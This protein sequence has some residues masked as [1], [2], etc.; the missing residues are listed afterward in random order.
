M[1]AIVREL[2]HRI[3]GHDLLVPVRH[4]LLAT[5]KSNPRRPCLPQINEKIANTALELFRDEPRR[6][7][8]AHHPRRLR[9]KP[10]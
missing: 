5:E 6:A 4:H 7:R 3:S 8:S 1:V 2:R 10:E 9:A